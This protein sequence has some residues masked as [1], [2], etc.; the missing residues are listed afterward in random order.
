M[1]QSLRDVGLGVAVHS[2]ANSVKTWTMGVVPKPAQEAIRPASLQARQAEC[3][4]GV[5]RWCRAS[6][7]VG[8]VPAGADQVVK[9]ESVVSS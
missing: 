4:P 6:C 5:L 2:R 7:Q 9:W 3:Y 8:G 1:V